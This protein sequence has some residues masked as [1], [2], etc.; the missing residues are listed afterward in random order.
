MPEFDD[1]GAYLSP[2][3]DL[4]VAGTTYKVP[5]PP[6]LVGLRLQAAW[7]VTNAR[8]AGVAA[9]AHHAALVAA[10]DGATSLEQDALGPVYDQMLA[11]GVSTE[12]LNHAGMTAY[13]WVVAGERAARLWW[14][15]PLGEARTPLPDRLPSTST[16]AAST[17]P[18]PASGSGTR[19]HPSSSDGSSSAPL[20]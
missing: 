17:T 6:A 3:L 10:D 20:A 16:D 14:V 13:L 11:D 1:L 4:P 9:K 8:Q 19:S 12:V 18:T 7:A 5:S 15:T 2:T